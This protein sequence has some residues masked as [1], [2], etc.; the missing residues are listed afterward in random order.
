MQTGPQTLEHFGVQIEVQKQVAI[1]DYYVLRQAA[2][3][4]TVAARVLPEHAREVRSEV[5][6]ML[7]G[8]VLAAP[9]P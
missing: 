6:R 4:A 5:E 8:A 7:R 2:G 1:M 3:G 9:Q